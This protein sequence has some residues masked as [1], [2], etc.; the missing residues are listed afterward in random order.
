MTWQA[1]LAIYILFW[2]MT[3]FVIL[4]FEAKTHDE[5]GIPKV[6]G[7]AESAPANFS[8][9]R[10]AIRTTILATLLFGLYYLNYVEGWISVETLTGQR[11]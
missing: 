1:A 7:Q 3:A 5:A 2:V 9:R 8:P 11:V 4:P 10:V 6:R